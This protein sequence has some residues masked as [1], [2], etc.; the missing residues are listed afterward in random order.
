M[1][2]NTSKPVAVILA[3]VLIVVAPIAVVML[4]RR[5]LEGRVPA[6]TPP[7]ASAGAETAR[8]RHRTLAPVELRET[9]KE[10]SRFNG[11]AM[12]SLEGTMTQQAKVD[13]YLP[14][15]EGE[16]RSLWVAPW[17]VHFKAEV[18]RNDGHIV[19]ERRT[20]EEVRSVELLT[21]A[22][23]TR[24]QYELGPE[25][26][27]A[28][29]G[30]AAT[31]A[32]LTGGAS[33]PLGMAMIK[34]QDLDYAAVSR[35]TGIDEHVLARQ[36]GM[37]VGAARIL[38]EFEGKTVDLRMQ[39]GR[40]QWVYAPDLPRKVVTTLGRVQSLL[41]YTALP[42]PSLEVGEQTNLT[43][44]PLHEVFP[45]ELTSEWFGDY[46][47]QLSLTLVRLPD[48]TVEQRTLA[49]F[50]GTG[51]LDL[52]H[53]DGNVY[54][55]LAVES[56]TLLVDHTAPDNRFLHQIELATPL[57]AGFVQKQSRFREVK[58]DGDLNL[59]LL[60]RVDLAP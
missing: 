38:D 52:L 39:D 33:V 46:N 13:V 12:G 45:A 25:V 27:K 8:P 9:R 18:L 50:D 6:A 37:L 35:L 11:F 30:V 19:E 40:V 34:S 51:M 41:D 7:I 14:V 21:P 15:F 36:E 43:D 55:K 28:I 10:G 26:N 17:S 60:Y 4:A 58:W 56:A 47:I 31:L 2:R 5:V 23:L 53:A 1:N 20:F 48:E 29:L 42:S 24:L 59:R 57:E 32:D 49:R 22:R 3:T 54:A 16:I 44:L